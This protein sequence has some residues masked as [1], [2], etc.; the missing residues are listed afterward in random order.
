MHDGRWDVWQYFRDGDYPAHQPQKAEVERLVVQFSDGWDEAAVRTVLESNADYLEAWADQHVAAATSLSDWSRLAAFAEIQW[1]VEDSRADLR[2]DSFGLP[3]VEQPLWSAMPDVYAQLSRDGL[4]RLAA[5]HITDVG[6]D[7]MAFAIGDEAVFPHPLLRPM[8]ELLAV[9]TDLTRDPELT[10]SIALDPY[11]QAKLAD[12][13]TRLLQDYWS[14]I[15]LSRANLDSLDAHGAGSTTFHFA[16]ERDAA[17]EFFNPLV[18]TTIDW[19]TRGD[20]ERDPVKRLYVRELKPPHSGRG[21]ELEAVHNRELHS[22][23]DTERRQFIHVDGKVRRYPTETYEI[24]RENP[25]GATGPHSH[26]CKLWRVDGPLTD[27]AWGDLVG[28]HF[29]GNEL[30]AEHF[31]RVFPGMPSA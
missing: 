3:R 15:K 23:R 7:D 5:N 21:E 1:L 8:R 10:V 18:A 24:H 13:S 20:D 12:V 19:A 6:G 17:Q 30:V 11:R 4:M 26:T 14:G 29:R 25:R 31:R 22:E 28:L 16:G 9:I 27:E 2:L